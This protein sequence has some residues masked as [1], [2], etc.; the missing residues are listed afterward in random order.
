MFETGKMPSIVLNNWQK[1]DL[2]QTFF[3]NVI[4]SWIKYLFLGT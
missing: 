3:D 4:N 1:A 2:F